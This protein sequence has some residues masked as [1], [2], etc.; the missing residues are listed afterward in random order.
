[1]NCYR[2]LPTSLVCE[3]I[4][5]FRFTL[6]NTFCQHLSRLCC[7]HWVRLETSLQGSYIFQWG[8]LQAWT[9]RMFYALLNHS[10]LSAWEQHSQ[11]TNRTLWIFD[12][13]TSWKAY[14]FTIIYQG[15]EE[16]W[17]IHCSTWNVFESLFS[18]WFTCTISGDVNNYIST[19]RW[20]MD[21]K[22]TQPTR[23]LR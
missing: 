7:Q 4:P 8:G 21:L 6:S 22:N 18:M 13:S 5:D 20:Y 15:H 16:P 23:T 9:C 19:G 11:T 12:N 14:I 2:P 3:P 1:M 17:R 10:V